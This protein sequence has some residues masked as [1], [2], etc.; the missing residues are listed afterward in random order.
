MKTSFE[1]ERAPFDRK[2]FAR[3]DENFPPGSGSVDVSSGIA[4]PWD[5]DSS[6]KGSYDKRHT[7]VSS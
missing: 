7:T 2:Y 6:S 5:I 4:K 3:A 1:F